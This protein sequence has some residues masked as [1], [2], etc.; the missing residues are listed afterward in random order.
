MSNRASKRFSKRVQQ[1]EL[2][3]IVGSYEFRKRIDKLTI[4]PTRRL[5]STDRVE[6]SVVVGCVLTCSLLYSTFA[7]AVLTNAAPLYTM[8][9]VFLNIFN[10]YNVA[11]HPLYWNKF[12]VQLYKQ[13][14]II[15]KY[16]IQKQDS[17]MQ[18]IDVI[19]KCLAWIWC[20]A[21]PIIAQ[22]RWNGLTVL[23]ILSIPGAS[24]NFRL[25]GHLFMSYPIEMTLSIISMLY[26]FSL[27]CLW[28]FNLVWFRLCCF[29][30]IVGSFWFMT[31]VFLIVYFFVRVFNWYV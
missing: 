12:H 31:S 6:F 9:F 29:F 30:S 2:G 27:Y 28:C 13:S 5:H 3:T 8:S 10:I 7:I 18:S 21:V 24:M 1:H 14:E 11:F 22:F 17:A 15:Q 25:A 20:A 23:F 26:I 4:I 16:F 19:K